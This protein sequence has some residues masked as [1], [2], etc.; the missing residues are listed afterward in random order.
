M[1]NLLA[2]VIFVKLTV[3][4]VEAVAAVEAVEAVAAVEAVW[5]VIVMSWKRG[6]SLDRPMIVNRQ[7]K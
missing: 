3:E 7:E 5:R 6:S 2:K 1:K 4:A